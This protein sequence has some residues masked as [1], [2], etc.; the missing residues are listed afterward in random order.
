MVSEELDKSEVTGDVLIVDDEKQDE[1]RTLCSFCRQEVDDLRKL[2]IVNRLIR[3]L[4][5]TVSSQNVSNRS[6]FL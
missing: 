3:E 4:G 1:L 2:V 5:R 6:D